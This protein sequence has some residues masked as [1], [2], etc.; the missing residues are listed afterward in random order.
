MHLRQ[1]LPGLLA[2]VAAG[3]SA[4]TAPIACTADLRPGLVVQ[5]R[6][7]QTNAPIAASSIVVIRDGD[8]V[9]SLAVRVE[10]G[11]LALSR[12]GAYERAGTYTVEV[13]HAGYLTL[14]IP[15]VVVPRDQCHVITNTI[16]ASM[17]PVP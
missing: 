9:E 5:V 13:S 10:G 7:E 3:C 15:G 2:I 12:Q 17:R 6:D 8:Y 4:C 11:A 16:A 14:G 1:F